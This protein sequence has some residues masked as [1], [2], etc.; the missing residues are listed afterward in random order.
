[1]S[2]VGCPVYRF[3]H[4]ATV[5]CF[6][7]RLFLPGALAST[8]ETNS[9]PAD[10]WFT[11]AFA[12]PDF[13]S[14]ATVVTSSFTQLEAV[15]SVGRLKIIW[16]PDRVDT[17]AAVRL[18]ASADEPGHW[19]ARDWREHPAI[20]GET[21]WEFKVPVDDADVPVAYFVEVIADGRTH[22]SP[23]RLT[24][25]RQLGIAEP[26][27]FFWA[28]IEGFETGT[29][30]WRQ[31]A[32]T[33]ARPALTDHAHSGRHALQVNVPGGK[34]STTIGTTRVR[35]WQ[36]DQ[37]RV[38]GLRLWLRTEAGTAT[39]AFTLHSDA[40]T[41]R[42]RISTGTRQAKLTPV[43]QQV[44]LPFDSFPGLDLPRVDWF[45]VTINSSQPCE[46]FMDDLEFLEPWATPS[47]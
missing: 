38:N 26:T 35:G 29:R 32:P 34:T 9:A 24:K 16:T 47:P 17:N 14:P 44:D 42:Q 5:I 43:W 31:T 39:A 22:V 20:Q 30:G 10:G 2:A 15:E 41:N 6:A 13:V 40:F 36:A 27:R 7:T 45:S 18:F 23:L 1:M 46:V 8:S 19:P 33:N 3:A 28:F 25:P 21:R 12:W 37:S 11:N 4:Y